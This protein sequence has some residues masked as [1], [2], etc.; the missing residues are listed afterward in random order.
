[1]HE[2]NDSYSSARAAIGL[3]PR[4]GRTPAQRQAEWR[5]RKRLEKGMRI[6]VWLSAE[7]ADILKA[8]WL[9]GESPADTLRRLLV[10]GMK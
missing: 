3:G 6:E 2:K 4:G 7:E 10:R 5:A 1:M 9:P 8:R